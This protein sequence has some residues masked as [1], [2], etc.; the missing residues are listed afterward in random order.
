MD[1][2]GLKLGNRK[3]W[4]ASITRGF[5][6]GGQSP[7]YPL[8]LGG[9]LNRS[10]LLREKKNLSFL[11][12][13]KPPFPHRPAHRLVTIPTELHRHLEHLYFPKPKYEGVSKIFRTDA[14]IYTA[15]VVPRSTGRW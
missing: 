8:R 10:E 13:N 15:V 3:E 1:P 4:P 12:E 6:P 7:W 11:P 2:L 14:T 5:R 9:F